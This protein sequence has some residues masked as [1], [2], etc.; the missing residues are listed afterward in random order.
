[1]SA[2]KMER[3]CVPAMIS[4]SRGWIFRSWTGTVGS[5]FMKRVHDP[6]RSVDT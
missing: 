1:M 4:L 5:P 3:P 6:P 2:T